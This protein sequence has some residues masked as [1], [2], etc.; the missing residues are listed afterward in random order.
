MHKIIA[1]A[2]G[3]LALVAAAPA[4]ADT[5]Y[6]AFTTFNGTNGA[7]GFNWVAGPSPPQPHCLG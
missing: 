1:Y 3:A 2:A 7:G 4:S 5:V 6:D